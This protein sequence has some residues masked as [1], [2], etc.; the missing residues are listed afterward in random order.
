MNQPLVSV[1]MPTY[2]RKEFL[3]YSIESILSQVYTNFEFLILDDSSDER[4]IDILNYYSKSDSRIKV[5]KFANH[6]DY[7]VKLNIGL[8]HARGKYIARMDDDISLPER[9]FSQVNFLEMHNDI[10]ACGTFI[11]SIDDDNFISWVNISEFDEIEVALNFYNPIAHPSIMINNEF[12][13]KNR[14]KYEEVKYKYAEDYA[15]WKDII[16]NKGKICNIPEA[17]VEIRVHNERVSN[18]KN[19]AK[20]QD[21]SVHCIRKELL[22]RFYNEEREILRAERGITVYPFKKTNSQHIESILNNMMRYADM[23]PISGIKKFKHR[24]C[25]DVSNIE[26]F[27]AA[28]DKFSM[29][30]CTCIVSLLSNLLDCEKINIHIL[31][32]GISAKGKHK[33]NLLRGIKNCSIEFIPINDEIFKNCPIADACSYISIQTY[34]RFI[35]PTI[36]PNIDKYIY[37]DSDIIICGSLNKL[38][39]SNIKDNYAIVVEDAWS[40]AHTIYKNLNISKNPF[41]AG[42]MLVNAKK[43]R[44][45]NIVDKLFINTIKLYN[46]KRLYWVDQDVLN[47]TLNKIKFIGPEYNLQQ[48]YYLD[49]EYTQYTELDVEK[50]KQSPIIIHYSGIKKPWDIG[51]VHP[52]WFKYYIYLIKTPYKFSIIRYFVII[53]ANKLLYGNNIWDCKL[54]IKLKNIYNKL[55]Q[56]MGNIKNFLKT[57]ISR[58]TKA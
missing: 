10:T 58:K 12:L 43:W 11:N 32:G 26:I 44:N 7:A 9:F 2:N 17:L 36:C 52:L 35:I 28:N 24:Y 54:R 14:I 18:S 33:I 46:E 53:L 49:T 37:L 1:I 25:G 42:M 5:Y 22:S 23:I 27:F 16:L 38:W 19:T 57:F 29:H 48:T 31:D 20:I 3:N 6:I 39:N 47:Y 50:A 8:Y 41:N 56:K 55:R 4:V 30:L 21:K 40:Y 13:K 45:D 15:L 34:Y 51:C